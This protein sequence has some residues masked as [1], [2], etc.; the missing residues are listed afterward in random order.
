[1]ALIESVARFQEL[2]SAF[3]RTWCPLKPQ[4]GFGSQ[5]RSV[6]GQFIFGLCRFGCDPNDD[7]VWHAAFAQ[8][9]ILRSMTIECR[10]P[11]SALP[12]TTARNL[13]GLNV[14]PVV[15]VKSH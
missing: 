8:G 9:R 14:L 10:I 11:G 2:L 7:H 4:D 3:E 15:A 12:E 5:E 1:M 13:N 6:R